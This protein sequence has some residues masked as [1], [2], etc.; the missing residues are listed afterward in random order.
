LTCIP[1]V[2]KKLQTKLLSGLTS[3]VGLKLRVI[4]GRHVLAA[5]VGILFTVVW[6]RFSLRLR[7]VY[8]H[9]ETKTTLKQNRMRF[10]CILFRHRFGYLQCCAIA[11]GRRQLVFQAQ[12]PNARCS[13]V[14]RTLLT[15]LTTGVF[16]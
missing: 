16:R 8:M 7:R 6:L 9:D 2:A 10:A 13:S 12:Q 4:L 3:L 11:H 5:Y 15:R 14:T 1:E